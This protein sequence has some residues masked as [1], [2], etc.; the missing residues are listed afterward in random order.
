MACYSKNLRNKAIIWQTSAK[1]NEKHRDFM[2]IILELWFS[3]SVSVP[4]VCFKPKKN[5]NIY[6]LCVF[7]IYETYK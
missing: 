7:Q 3:A 6:V 1:V 4:A 2:C 5:V